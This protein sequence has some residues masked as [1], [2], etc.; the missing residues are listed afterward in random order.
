[1]VYAD[2]TPLTED[3]STTGLTVAS[4]AWVY[5]GQAVTVYA[6]PSSITLFYQTPSAAAPQSPPSAGMP[7]TTLLALCVGVLVVIGIAAVVVIGRRK[8]SI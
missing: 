2:S 6:D 1:M 4:N 5:Q 3:T 7:A 8:K